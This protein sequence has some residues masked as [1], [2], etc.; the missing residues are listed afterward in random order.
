MR[1]LRAR[2]RAV[3]VTVE[4]RVDIRRFKRDDAAP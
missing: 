3:V 4:H 2:R 1:P